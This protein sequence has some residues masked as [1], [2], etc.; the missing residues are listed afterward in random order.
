M[1]TSTLLPMWRSP[2]ACADTCWET[3][4]SVSETS[5]RTLSRVEQCLNFIAQVQRLDVRE[6]RKRLNDAEIVLDVYLEPL[7]AATSEPLVPPTAAPTFQVHKSLRD[8]D[9]LRAQVRSLSHPS[10]NDRHHIINR[11]KHARRR[12]ETMPCQLC[13]RLGFIHNWPSRLERVFQSTTKTN[14]LLQTTMSDL[15]SAVRGCSDGSWHQCELQRHLPRLLA[16]F[17]VPELLMEE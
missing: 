9:R 11:R 13:E 17:L 12:F 6:T 14:E 10:D 16:D 7:S 15:L 1:T 5:T 2:T 3:E 4:T 8:F